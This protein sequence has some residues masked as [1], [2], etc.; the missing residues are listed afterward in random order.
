[1]EVVK[2]VAGASQDDDDQADLLV[3]KMPAKPA[4]RRA[5]LCKSPPKQ[6]RMAPLDGIGR[7]P[8]LKEDEQV[9]SDR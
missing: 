4:R 5:Y 8:W 3:V 6:P 2:S 9:N 1:V 7:V